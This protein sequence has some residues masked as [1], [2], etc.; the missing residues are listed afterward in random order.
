[1]ILLFALHTA[2]AQNRITTDEGVKFIVG[3]SDHDGTKI[4]HIILPTYYA[5]ARSSSKAKES[6]GTMAGLCAM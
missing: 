3:V 1:M 4:P 5:Y 6:T 2:V